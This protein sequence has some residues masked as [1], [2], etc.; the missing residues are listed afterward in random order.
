MG[1]H[2][3]ARDPNAHNRIAHSAARF[4]VSLFPVE[5][6]AHLLEPFY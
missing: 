3:D 1:R 6:F 5:D 2:F 4:L